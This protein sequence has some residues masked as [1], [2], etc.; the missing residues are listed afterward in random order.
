[1]L[2][3]FFAD[4]MADEEGGGDSATDPD[5]KVGSVIN[6][7]GFDAAGEILIIKYFCENVWDERGGIFYVK[8][9]SRNAQKVQF[10]RKFPWCTKEKKEWALDVNGIFFSLRQKFF[11]AFPHLSDGRSKNSLKA[12]SFCAL[13]SGKS[14][15]GSVSRPHCYFPSLRAKKTFFNLFSFD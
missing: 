13:Y 2:C 4:A 5:L 9:V 14:G 10:S 7:M 3:F 11:L 6:P 15:I 8:Y 1:M 12:F